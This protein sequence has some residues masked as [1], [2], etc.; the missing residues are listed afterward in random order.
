MKKISCTLDLHGVYHKDVENI[1]IDHFFWK[2]NVDSSVITG[3]SPQMKNLVIEWLE[4]NEFSYH[5]SP[6]NLGRIEVLS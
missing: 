6:T 2:G 4:E 3:D 1:L 5:I